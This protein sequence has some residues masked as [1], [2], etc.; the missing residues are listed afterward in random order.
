LILAGAFILYHYSPIRAAERTAQSVLKSASEVIAGFT[1]D[2]IAVT[3]RNE[4]TSIADTNGGLLEVARLE[5]TEEFRREVKSPFRGTTVSEIK[6]RAVFKYHVPLR[7]GWSIE[8]EES[9]RARVCQ[10]VAPALVPSLPVAFQSESLEAKSAEGWLRWDGD[11]EM[12]ALMASVTPGL[13]ERAHRNLDLVKDKAR[14]SIKEFVKTWLL[15]NDQW[16]EDRFSAIEVKFADEVSEVDV[17]AEGAVA[18]E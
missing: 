8:I 17:P 13:E 9:P 12:D 6:A 15:D 10:V 16:R 5:S 1:R 18:I 7:D 2:D 11:T 14:R 4:L 3:F